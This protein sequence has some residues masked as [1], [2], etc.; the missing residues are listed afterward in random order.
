MKFIDLNVLVVGVIETR[1]FILEQLDFLRSGTTARRIIAQRLHH[2]NNKLSVD[3]WERN[4][5]VVVI[6]EVQ[7]DKL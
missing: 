2:C 3:D 7:F 6:D 5:S 1:E 4:F